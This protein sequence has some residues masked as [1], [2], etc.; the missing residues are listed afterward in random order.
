MKFFL[1]FKKKKMR[2]WLKYIML[3]EVISMI[4]S[5][6]ISISYFRNESNAS[7]RTTV[8]RTLS[9]ELVKQLWPMMCWKIVFFAS[10]MKSTIVR[11]IH[12]NKKILYFLVTSII[13]FS[14][15]SFTQNYIWSKNC[16]LAKRQ[17]ETKLLF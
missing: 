6:L 1:F 16:E 4:L 10:N 13:F 8:Q 14:R 3:W 12:N 2:I 5:Q 17:N 7:E 9:I 15:E 11:V